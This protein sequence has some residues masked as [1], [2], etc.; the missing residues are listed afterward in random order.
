VQRL[1]GVQPTQ[2]LVA[3]LAAC[4]ALLLWE[5]REQTLLFDE[6]SF[7][8]DYRGHGPEV[9]LNPFSGNLELLPILAYKA[10]F[11]L[12]GPSSV[13][14]RLL[15]VAFNLTAATLVF[16]LVRGRIGGWIALPCA[17]LIATLG[18]AAD[19]VAATLGLG[20]DGI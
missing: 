6:W 10:V 4:A 5:M 2:V 1:R 3:A 9:L 17:V 14:L 15:L 19:V 18:V 20:W 11:A 16:L 8:A 7:F 12:F 13:A